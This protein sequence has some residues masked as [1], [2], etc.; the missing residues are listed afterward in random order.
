MGLG[1]GFSSSMDSAD[2]DVLPAGTTAV[3]SPPVPLVLTSADDDGR[4]VGVGARSGE[5]KPCV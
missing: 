4:Q 2:I 3:V 1:S 5:E